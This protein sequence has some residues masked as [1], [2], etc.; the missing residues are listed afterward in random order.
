MTDETGFRHRI[1]Q[2]M[3][4]LRGAH[5]QHAPRESVPF[6]RDGIQRGTTDPD[7]R[8]SNAQRTYLTPQAPTRGTQGPTH[9]T[10]H[11]QDA[12][13]QAEAARAWAQQHRQSHGR[14]RGMG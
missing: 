10:Q 2:M 6:L 1:A 3:S 8:S 12:A 14:G 9:E 7:G 4:W 11:Q 5:P 13:R